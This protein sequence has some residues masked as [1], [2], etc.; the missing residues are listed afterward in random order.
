MADDNVTPLDNQNKNKDPK[1]AALNKIREAA[2]KEI[3]AKIE[4]QVKKTLDAKK[5]FLNEK[6][7]LIDL[8]SEAEDD[9]AEFA[10][11]IKEI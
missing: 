4:A 5:I 9:K 2:T 3:N 11:L 10:D 6:K 1:Q 7:A 8:L